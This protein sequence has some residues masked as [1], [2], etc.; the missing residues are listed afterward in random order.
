[1]ARKTVKELTRDEAFALA[2]EI[3]RDIVA[4]RALVAEGA[5]KAAEFLC[6]KPAG[7]YNM[8]DLLG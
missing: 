8:K 4:N 2:D 3:A 6:G 5:L 7:L 1:M